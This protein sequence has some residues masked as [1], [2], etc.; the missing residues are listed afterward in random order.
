MGKDNVLRKLPSV[1][2][3]ITSKEIKDI[4]EYYDREI[5]VNASRSVLNDVRKKILVE[6]ILPADN[7]FSVETLGDAVVQWLKN[8]Y[9]TTSLTYAV[10]ATGIIMHTGLGRSLLA[11]TVQEAIK[12]V[13]QGYCTL[14][15]EPESGR[16][17]HRDVHLEKILCDITGAEAAT[18]ANNNA[19]ATMLIL[20]T[21]AKGKEVIVSRGQLVEIG[22]AFRL[23]Q[24]METSGC[25]LKEVGTTN[26]THLKDY[27]AA[28]NENTGAILRV[29][30]SNYRIDGFFEEPS[31]EELITVGRKHNVAV[32]DDLGSGAFVDLEPYGLKNEPKV[33]DSV[34]A[35]ADVSC[36]SGDKL[37]GGP[38][39]GIIV[40]K[41]AIIDQI[42]KNQLSR[43]FRLGKITIAGLIAACKLFLNKKKLNQNHPTFAMLSAPLQELKERAEKIV[44]CCSGSSLAAF[45]VTQGVS[46]VGSGAVPA[47]TVPTYLISL[48][49]KKISSQRLAHR[50]RSNQPPIFPRLHQET[51][52]L[53]LRTIQPYED[54]IVRDALQKI[55]KE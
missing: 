35:G 22:G 38:Q 15:I 47:E 37:I 5:I 32:I 42:K 44:D 29:H 31:I 39:A 3:I 27:A 20:N 7:D 12:Q 25:I 14:A 8:R 53:D 6:N 55:S 1:D 36:F 28:I 48:I 26:K 11:P 10:N 24:V 19:A 2:E 54:T 41:K 50:L 30:H 34:K 9:E 40:G 16:R 43:A 21:L 33:Q 17:G 45:S 4:L 13:I 49:P 51:I 46:Q 18:T 52:L 23:P